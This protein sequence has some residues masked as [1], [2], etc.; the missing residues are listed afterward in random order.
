MRDG[1]EGKSLPFVVAMA[2]DMV[3]ASANSELRAAYLSSETAFVAGTEL[4]PSNPELVCL[5]DWRLLEMLLFTAGVE[6]LDTELLFE[7]KK[8]DSTAR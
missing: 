1:E 6:M 8:G 7:G 5:K 3:L 4:V 2:E